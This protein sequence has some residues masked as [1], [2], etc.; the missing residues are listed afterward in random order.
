MH[1]LLFLAGATIT[2]SILGLIFFTP[3]III[4][5][6]IWFPLAALLALSVAGFLSVIGFYAAVIG[7]SSWVYKYYRGMNPVESDQFDYARS[8]ISD[9]TSHV[10]DYAREFGYLHDKMKDAAPGT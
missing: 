4:F 3:F 2:T 5:S 7:G 9:T 6:P 1:F 10:K 8:R